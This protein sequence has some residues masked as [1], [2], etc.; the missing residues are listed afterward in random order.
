MRTREPE[1]G[2]ALLA[3]M[4]MLLV[5][6]L[7]AAA[8]TVWSHNFRLRV[9]R[10]AKSEPGYYALESAAHH[11]LWLLANDMRRNSSV[12]DLDGVDYS[13]T[14]RFVADGRRHYFRVAGSDCYFELRVLDFFSGIQL[15]HEPPRTALEFSG[16][17]LTS[18][19]E[20]ERTA[21]LCNRL[22]DYVDSDDLPEPGGLEAE[23][24]TKLGLSGLPRNAVARRPEEY[25]AIPGFTELFPP[26]AFGRMNWFVPSGYPK[27]KPSIFAAPH[28]LA[29]MMADSGESGSKL[30]DRAFNEWIEHGRTL[31]ETIGAAD[32]AMWK[33]I[34]DKFS[35]TE[36]GYYVLL[37]RPMA[38]SG[39]RGRSLE[40]VIKLD[41][42]SG[43]SGVVLTPE[44]V[45]VR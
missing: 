17:G 42:T 14:E 21:I 7:L 41:R 10:L 40:F 33:I 34:D 18:A 45:T 26:D 16:N 22:F 12:G 32:P 24:Y 31:D 37:V 43:I 1:R 29:A 36:S 11:G 9:K 8:M 25:A 15:D 39:L 4:L 23:L 28:R 27:T 35:L 3:A 38:E 5:L 13:S 30:L 19:D 20:F 2:A 6:A 44:T